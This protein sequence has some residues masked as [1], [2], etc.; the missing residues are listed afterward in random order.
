VII[1]I[2]TIGHSTRS[3]PEFISLLKEN[4]I[5][6]IADVRRRPYS[7]KFPQFNREALETNLAVEGIGYLWLEAL[8]GWRRGKA[9]GNSPNPGL[10]SIGLRN[11]ADHMHTGEFE[12]AVELLLAAA[13]RE[14]TAIL[15]AERLFW[16]CHRRLLCDHLVSRGTEVVHIQEEGKICPH[17]VTPG[18][19]FTISGVI[20]PEV[21][22]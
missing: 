7:Q 16:K 20:Y 21:Q 13:A 1:K 10:R 15:C 18:A 14:L 11:Y 12:G 3:W 22:P 4:G 5:R 2:F 8:G 19:V 9:R 6:M 17:K